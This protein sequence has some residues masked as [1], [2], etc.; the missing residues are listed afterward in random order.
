MVCKTIGELKALIADLPDDLPV[1]GY[2]GR[3]HTDYRDVLFYVDDRSAEEGWE[4]WSQ[5]PELITWWNGP[6][7]PVVFVCN[8]D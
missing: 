8:T 1:A 7:P 2:D 3:D 6:V 5:K 4:Q